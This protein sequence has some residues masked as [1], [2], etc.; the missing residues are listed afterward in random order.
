M[1]GEEFNYHAL[2]LNESSTEHDMK[3]AYRKLVI[4]S[5]PEKK[6]HPRASAVMGMINHGKEGLEDLFS[7]NDAMR[8]QEEDLQH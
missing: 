6:N 3:K 5:H 1:E 2:G 7:Y 4:R 8:K